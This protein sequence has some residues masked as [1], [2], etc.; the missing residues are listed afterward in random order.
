MTPPEPQKHASPLL[1]SGESPSAA[2]DDGRHF[3]VVGDRIIIK[4]NSGLFS[5]CSVSLHGIIKFFNERHRLPGAVD[6]NQ[7][8]ANFNEPGAGIPNVY[9]RYFNPDPEVEIKFRSRIEFPLFSLFDYRKERFRAV[10]PFVQ[11][12]F[13]PSDAVM[14]KRSALSAG[15][16]VDASHLLTI[17]YRGTDKFRDTNLGSFDTF[18]DR[19]EDILQKE[20]TLSVLIQTD[21][22]QFLDRARMRLGK[23]LVFDELPRTETNT[24]MHRI[25]DRG[26][27]DWTQTFIGAVHFIAQSKYLV[28]HTG[29]VARWIC[30]YRGQA[31]RVLQFYHPKGA[32]DGDWL[33]SL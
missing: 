14:A 4:H 27:V 17:C 20:P 32:A 33:G 10:A 3:V 2:S 26:K 19:A 11:R 30:L 9:E 28:L 25:V 24:V 29:N 16:G 15:L 6:F 18:L 31:D 12:Y 7:C 23:V 21:Q 1:P 8:F 5:N 22:S 13:R